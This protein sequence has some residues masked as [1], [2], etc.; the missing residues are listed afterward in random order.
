MK[1]FTLWDNTPANDNAM[2]LTRTTVGRADVT[3]A[4]GGSVAVLVLAFRA[5]A[6][7]G[8]PAALCKR[9]VQS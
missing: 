5:A 2:P 1:L 6:N 9:P 7:D 8:L 4:A 3:V